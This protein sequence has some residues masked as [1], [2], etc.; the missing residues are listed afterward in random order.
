MLEVI[1]VGLPTGYSKRRFIAQMPRT[2]R[3]HPMAA[4]TPNEVDGALAWY[5]KTDA[6]LDPAEVD[7]L[8]TECEALAAA[9]DSTLLTAG[10]RV[11]QEQAESRSRWAALSALRGRS[12]VEIYDVVQNR[13]DSWTSLAEAKA[14]FREWMPLLFAAVA[15]DIMKD[16]STG[17]G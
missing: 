5:F 13:I 11:R 4:G 15:W 16:T 9:Y 17:E 8:Q 7:L 3:G 6:P 12:V 10:E 1:F 14:D 2:V